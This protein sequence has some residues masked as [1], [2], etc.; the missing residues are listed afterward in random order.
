MAT[1]TT[2][3]KLIA[4]DSYLTFS[5]WNKGSVVERNPRTRPD[6][7]FIEKKVV[8][9]KLESM[10]TTSAYKSLMWLQKLTNWF[11]I[12]LALSPIFSAH[13]C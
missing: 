4:Q 9:E 10:V 13:S 7:E 3:V 1:S 2:G 12:T 8:G 6:R 5:I 11:G